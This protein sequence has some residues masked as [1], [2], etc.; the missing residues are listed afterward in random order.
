MLRTRS[1]RGL[2]AVWSVPE[3]VRL[4]VNQYSGELEDVQLHFANL[5]GYATK[6]RRQKLVVVPGILC[7]A[8]ANALRD[9]G[10][11]GSVRLC[12]TISW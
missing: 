11:Y 7:G 12:A 8:V 2:P 9:E 6:P 10:L 4:P 1:P 5:D 3:R